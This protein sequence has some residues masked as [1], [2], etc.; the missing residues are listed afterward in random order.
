MAHPSEARCVMCDTPLMAPRAQHSLLCMSA[1]CAGR[2]AHLRAHEKCVE[3]AR[4]LTF[5]QQ[6][7]RLCDH[8][9]CRHVR[10]VVRPA[11]AARDASER[12]HVIAEGKRDR[13]LAARGVPSDARD[14]WPVAVVPKHRARPSRLPTARRTAFAE[15]LTALLRG[16]R[17]RF[18]AGERLAPNLPPSS[19]PPLSSRDAQV[20]ALLA[21]TCAACRGAC[22][23]GGGPNHAYLRE[24]A[25]LAYMQRF[26]DA[27]DD[28]ILAHYLSYVPERTLTGGCVYQRAD[29]CTLPRNLRA[30]ICNRYLCPGL[31]SLRDRCGG[32]A[33]VQAYVAHRE[34]PEITGGRFLPVLPG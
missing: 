29:G 4:P 31:L 25:M 5:Q 9:Q 17:A 8:P 28:D 23:H 22:C 20:D 16:A 14:A 18:A 3:C 26:P 19:A 30:D 12:L 2:Y 1:M 34:G 15:H 24:D 27:T 6:A 7:S 33:P 13:A 10:L 11:A 21:A 32:D